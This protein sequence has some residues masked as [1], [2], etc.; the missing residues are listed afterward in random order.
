MFV[1]RYVPA[2]TSS[3]L[4][5][6]EHHV[7]TEPLHAS[8]SADC[9]GG[10]LLG[11]LLC[12]VKYADGSQRKT[13]ESG[14]HN[15]AHLLRTWTEMVAERGAARKWVP[16]NTAWDMAAAISLYER[17][18]HASLAHWLDGLCELCRGAKVNQDR[19]TCTC[20]GGTGRAQ[21]AAGR[22]ETQLILDMVSELEGIFQA[23]SSRAATKLRRVA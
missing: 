11:S 13:F 8:A 12:R 19:R 9:A 10:A 17:V 22:L 5:D 23:H 2:L 3:D 20:C 6:D 7:A 1:E 18:A 16:A 4:R 14:S 21:V 15:L